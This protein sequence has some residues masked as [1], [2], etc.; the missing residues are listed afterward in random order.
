MDA[1]EAPRE[2][3]GTSFLL[4]GLSVCNVSWG[5]GVTIRRNRLTHR[6]R[7]RSLRRWVSG[8]GPAG[9]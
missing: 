1:N 7:S 3:S 2:G 8:H 5:R 4:A 9:T 6:L